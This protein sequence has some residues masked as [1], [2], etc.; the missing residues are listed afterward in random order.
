MATESSLAR[1]LEIATLG[2]GG[3]ARVVLAQD[4]VLGRPVALKRLRASAGDA[5]GLMRFR[6]EALTWLLLASGA[7]DRQDSHIVSFLRAI[8]VSTD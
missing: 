4:R 3:M 5:R 7:S 8:G 6:R 2:A 1:Y